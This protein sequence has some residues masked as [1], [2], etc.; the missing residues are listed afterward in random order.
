MPSRCYSSFFI[1]KQCTQSEIQKIKT[2][3]SCTLPKEDPKNL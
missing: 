3:H 2:W 1:E